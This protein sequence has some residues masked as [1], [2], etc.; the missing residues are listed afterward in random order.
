MLI[1]TP[2]ECLD[3]KGPENIYHHMIN[4]FINADKAK[5]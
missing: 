4:L 2:K 1:N 3:K 5:K